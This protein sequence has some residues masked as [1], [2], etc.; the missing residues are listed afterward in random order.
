MA[1]NIVVRF[2]GETSSLQRAFAQAT[3]GATAMEASTGSLGTK[4]S[5]LG[6]KMAALGRSFTMATIP[7]ALLSGVMVKSAIDYE[8]T[9]NKTMRLADASVADTKRWSKEIIA[10]S[11]DVGRGPQELAE[12]LY[13]VTSSGIPAAAAMDVLKVSA[14][15]AAV[16]M[17]DAK[18]VADLLTS[19]I[20]AYGASNITAAESADIVTATVRRGKGEADAFAHSMG[21]MA[22]QAAALGVSFNDLGAS[23]AVLTNNG[24]STHEAATRVNQ[25]MMN[26]IKPSKQA[27]EAIAAAGGSFDE[28]RKIIKEKGLLEAL[29]YMRE[30]AG[31]N[32]QAFATM[33]PNVRALNAALI[34]TAKDGAA[35][36]NDIFADL[37]DASG[38]LDKSFGK[39][40]E[41]TK[42]KLEKAWATLQ[43][44]GIEIGTA[45]MPIVEDAATL[46]ADW[47]A[48][49]SGL[50]D[51]WKTGIAAV[52]AVMVLIGPAV[53]AA[54]SVISGFGKVLSGIAAHPA[55][56][57]FAVLVLVGVWLYNNWKPFHD[58]I[59]KVKDI[60]TGDGMKQGIENFSKGLEENTRISKKSY[61]QLGWWQRRMYDAGVGFG[62]LGD[63]W[64]IT[65]D[66]MTEKWH[67]FQ[68]AMSDGAFERGLEEISSS[69]SAGWDEISA[70]FGR[71]LDRIYEL[72]EQWGI[73]QA[74]TAVWD[75]IKQLFT[76]TLE[77]M[78]GLFK[79]FTSVFRGEWGNAWNA[80]KDIAAAIWDWIFQ[81]FQ[82]VVNLVIASGRGLYMGMA[83]IWNAIWNVVAYIGSL[84]RGAFGGM[85]DGMVSALSAAWSAITWMWNGIWGFIK[86]I[87]GA[88]GGAVAGAWD[89]LAGSFKGAINTII[90]GWNRLSFTMPSVNTPFGTIGGWTLDTPNIPRMAKGGIVDSATLAIIGEAGREVVFP[91]NNPRRGFNL[92]QEAGVNMPLGGSTTVA[93]EPT[94]INYSP[95]FT[96]MNP[97]DAAAINEREYYWMNKTNGR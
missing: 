9:L 92:L 23:M 24:L 14:K 21:R 60:L 1:T 82:S 79:F 95:S 56:A 39:L 97:R 32:D 51:E 48:K 62:E 85:W 78:V 41:T 64:A 43:G 93:N 86:S 15:A 72:M 28:V 6:T 36:T 34:L 96:L 38:D 18:T 30:L 17:G 54:G 44:I 84:I 58:L 89:G 57:T 40:S 49:F 7:V 66:L 69:F 52:L 71:G 42:F 29:K 45:L 2:I 3:A 27:S 88:I 53:W 80:I 19:V 10:L 70:R 26:I 73:I 33:L 75:F 46:L 77:I 68:D 76:S 11:A 94:V 81:T 59:E 13:F 31:G 12:A 37:R 67:G 63:N 61:D 47:G 16:G 65:S 74:F 35:T 20:N 8:D 83:N 22:P 55:L 87:P 4:I 25:V 90:D 50:G 91:T 5:G